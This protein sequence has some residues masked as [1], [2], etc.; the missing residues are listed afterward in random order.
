MAGML[1]DM[2]VKDKKI[3]ATGFFTDP[4][5][6]SL[7]VFPFLLVSSLSL[8]FHPS[9]LDLAVRVLLIRTTDIELTKNSTFQ[10]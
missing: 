8:P 2:T 5:L 7:E 4:A 10:K 1:A 9:S 6:Q 3:D